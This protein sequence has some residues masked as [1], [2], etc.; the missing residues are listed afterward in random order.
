[1]SKISG[2]DYGNIETSRQV[3][4]EEQDRY[5]LLRVSLPK[6]ITSPRLPHSTSRPPLS[7]LK[8]S[9]LHPTLRSPSAMQSSRAGE[10]IP[11]GFVLLDQGNDDLVLQIQARRR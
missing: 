8:R 11:V 7:A 10:V 5:T 3:L 2:A 4:W 1:M 6:A 9:S